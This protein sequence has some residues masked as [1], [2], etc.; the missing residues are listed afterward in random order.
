MSSYENEYMNSQ[1][2]TFF[3]H[4]IKTIY[5][6]FQRAAGSRALNREGGTEIMYVK[7]HKEKKQT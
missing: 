6:S 3:M 4:I 1:F 7:I 5:S 2:C